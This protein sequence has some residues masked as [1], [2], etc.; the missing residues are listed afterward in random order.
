MNIKTKKAH[1]LF[2]L[3][4]LWSVTSLTPL[5]GLSQD[6][7]NL[8]VGSPMISIKLPLGT[9]VN[10]TITDQNA[11]ENV[12]W[13]FNNIPGG[14]VKVP[15]TGFTTQ[16]DY[17]GLRFTL[18]TGATESNAV[19]PGSSLTIT[20]T[21]TDPGT[22]SFGLTLTAG[23]KTSD[24]TI[25]VSVTKDLEVVLVLDRSGSMTLPTTKG[26]RRW[27][28][29][30]EAAKSFANRYGNLKRANDHV[31]IIYFESTPTPPSGCCN[32]AK[33]VTPTLATD[34]TNDF[35][36]K[37]PANGATA[38]GDALKLAQSKL[39]PITPGKMPA[40]VFFTDGEQNPPQINNEGNGYLGGSGS[41]PG[42]GQP[43]NI[44]FFTIGFEG[45]AP[46]GDLLQRLASH[47][48]GT[49][50]HTE[51]GTD[52]NNH[53]DDALNNM[54]SGMSPQ[55]VARS[56]HNV[57]NNGNMVTLETFP[58]NNNV[59]KLQL[60]FVFGTSFETP[61]LFQALARMRVEK[62]GVSMLQYA[63]PSIAGNFS[64]TLLLTLDFV[65][66]PRSV[67]PINP[68]GQWTVSISDS[69]LK[70]MNV[71]LSVTADDHRLH[72]TRT[73]GVGRPA[74]DKPLKITF[75]LDWLGHPI[76]NATVEAIIGRPGEDIQHQLAINTNNVQVSNSPDAGTPGRQKFDKLWA[77]ANFRAQFVRN[78]NVVMLSHTAD[79]KYEGTFNGLTVTGNYSLVIRVT[80]TDSTAGKIQ[81]LVSENFYTGIAGVDMGKSSIT[82]QILNGQL[83]MNIKP[84]QKRNDNKVFYVGP[85]LTNSF[86]VSNPGITI[87]K[88]DDHQ[89]GSYTITFNGNINDTT[90]LILM[91]DPIY[92]GKLTNA[93]KGGSG[94]AGVI[95]KFKKWFND[96]GIPFWVFWLLIALLILLI[97]WLLMRRRKSHT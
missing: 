93:G 30:T 57:P 79:G 97:L 65:T 35:V 94:G 90:T 59:D 3:V 5:K 58:L 8:D 27:D 73:L 84:V 78:D 75:N 6:F 16:F 33:L 66:P 1:R 68:A 7:I 25:E 44:K 22:F 81:R 39:S 37:G 55:L 83:V 24:A 23:A 71:S 51:T 60:Q 41:I 61:Q 43:N 80:G 34:F 32:D 4:I 20:Q 38:M 85:G 52:L 50:H 56:S 13:T 47:T 86:G 21:P 76:Q 18:P 49:Y 53:F 70:Y 9:A 64:N 19:S 62:D 88:V 89:D 92:T 11:L 45:T 26:G 54:L 67:P 12:F 15:A 82:T 74:I 63:R 46:M 96:H 40:I 17:H 48:G 72:M 91:G 42:V 87:S 95:D 2:W 29:L 77:D 36:G 14:A 28:A 69:I 10:R 31:R